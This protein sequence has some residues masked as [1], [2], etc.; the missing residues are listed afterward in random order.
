M[1]PQDGPPLP[2]DEQLCGAA[3]LKSIPAVQLLHDAYGGLDPDTRSDSCLPM[4]RRHVVLDF[5]FVGHHHDCVLTHTLRPFHA[6]LRN[7]VLRP[8]AHDHGGHVHYRQA[9]G[10]AGAPRGCQERTDG[11]SCVQRTQ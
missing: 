3:K 9:V 10:K 7:H 4:Q 6:F 5:H 1:H 2:L 11:L 8:S